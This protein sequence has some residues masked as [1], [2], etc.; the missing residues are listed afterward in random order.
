MRESSSHKTFVCKHE[1]V[2]RTRV[3]SLGHLCMQSKVEILWPF[4]PSIKSFWWVMSTRDP[5]LMEVDCL[6]E[7]GI[8]GCLLNCAYA[9]KCISVMHIHMHTNVRKYMAKKHTLLNKCSHHLLKW[10]FLPF[11]RTYCQFEYYNWK[12]PEKKISGS[13]WITYLFLSL[14]TY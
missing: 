13:I 2:T 5:V 10:K 11:W 9:H 12:L 1:S 8:Q 14:C 4:Q 6:F 3:K 7:K